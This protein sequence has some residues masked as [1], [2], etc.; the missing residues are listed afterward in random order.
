M[1]AVAAAKAWGRRSAR[2]AG[3]GLA[4]SRGHA[5]R[6]G[7]EARADRVA[8]GRDAARCAGHK[9]KAF[10]AC[11]SAGCVCTAGHRRRPC[12]VACSPTVMPDMSERP[13]GEGRA[14]ALRH[15]QTRRVV[16]PAPAAV[17]A[18]CSAK[19]HDVGLRIRGAA[20]SGKATLALAVVS[21]EQDVRPARAL[22]AEGAVPAPEPVRRCECPGLPW[23]STG[24]RKQISPSIWPDV[25]WGSAQS[26]FRRTRCRHSGAS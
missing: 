20:R 17:P 2:C 18:P 15:L 26:N 24:C 13:K 23:R 25:S 3:G 10:E 6:L 4:G 21:A 8:G 7:G 9:H 22:E 12:G 19:S 14:I 11:L 1:Q 16:R 5:G